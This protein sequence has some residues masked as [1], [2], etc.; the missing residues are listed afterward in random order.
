MKNLP[1]GPLKKVPDKGRC[2]KAFHP[3][4]AIHHHTHKPDNDMI[5]CCCNI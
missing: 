3:T 1:L 5:Q 4:H 2:S